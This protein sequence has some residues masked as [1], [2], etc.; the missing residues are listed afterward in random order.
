[1]E[2]GKYTEREAR[3]PWSSSSRL[4]Q[5]RLGLR[6]YLP[7]RNFKK[8]DEAQ[9]FTNFFGTPNN[10]EIVFMLT[11]MRFLL[12]SVP[13]KKKNSDHGPT[14]ITFKTYYK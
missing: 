14:K 11:A 10:N 4:W 9:C 13:L 6:V 5:Y 7:L 3:R 8:L 1:M 2:G 12:Y